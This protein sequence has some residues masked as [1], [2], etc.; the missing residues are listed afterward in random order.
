MPG[1]DWRVLLV[2]PTGKRLKR[3]PRTKRRDY[4]SDQVCPV[5]VWNQ[6]NNI[7]HPSWCGTRRQRFSTNTWFSDKPPK[8]NSANRTCT[9]WQLIDQVTWSHG[10]AH[11][12]Q[13]FK[14][15]LWPSNVAI[16]APKIIVSGRP[17]VSKHL[18]DSDIRSWTTTVI[19]SQLKVVVGFFRT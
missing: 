12:Q 6:K 4:I 14:M 5:L 17:A 19:A 3:R 11:A 13:T 9:G 7:P 2:T 10:K 15:D 1:K 18:L 16:R 8:F